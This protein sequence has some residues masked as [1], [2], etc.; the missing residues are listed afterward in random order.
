[1]SFQWKD[2]LT[3]AENLYQNVASI[4]PEEANYRTA[5]NRAYY[6]VHNAS[7]EYLVNYYK[8]NFNTKDSIHVQVIDKLNNKSDRKEK[9]ISKKLDHLRWDRKQV[10][11]ELNPRIERNPPGSMNIRKQVEFD[12]RR[13]NTIFNHLAELIQSH[14]N[15]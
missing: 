13:A 12:I 6:A 7:R 11:Y 10:D 8:E 2:F 14:T 1:M 5:I 15:T 4:Q 3:L 9:W